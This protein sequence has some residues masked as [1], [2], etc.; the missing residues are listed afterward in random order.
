MGIDGE[1]GSIEV[2][3]RAD[4]A[5]FDLN[6]PSIQPAGTPAQQLVWAASERDLVHTLV[7]GR[8]M[9]RD[10]KLVWQNQDELLKT[11]R[12]EAQKLVSRAGL[13]GKVPFGG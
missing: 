9:V 8:F 2:G 10:R 13:E 7:N 11:A 5:L 3:K 1:L 12:R 4:L 6:H